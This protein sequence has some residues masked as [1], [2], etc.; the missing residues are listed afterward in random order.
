MRFY[1]L[2]AVALVTLLSTPLSA[3]PRLEL[4]Q[5]DHICLI[6]NTL[7]DRMQH[8]GWLET[9]L[10]SRFPD[11]ELVIRNLGFAG[12]EVTA[13]PRSKNFGDPDSHL[14]HSK[15]D[16]IFVF[17]GYNESFGDRRG[18]DEFKNDLAELVYHMEGQ[19]YN[20]ESAPRIVL[21]SPIGHENLGSS[22]LPSGI[23]NN[24]R[25]A[26]Y[27]RAIH[28]VAEEKNL[29]YVDLVGPST[30][31]YDSVGPLTIN[32]IHLTEKGNRH[33]AEVIDQALFGGRQS[34]SEVD[35]KLLREAILDK[36][37]HW[38]NRYR[39]TDGYSQFGNRAFL[40]F[41]DQ[42]DNF[43]VMQRELERLDVMT[44]NR[45]RRIWAIARGGDLEVQDDNLPEHVPVISNFMGKNEDGSH[46]FVSGEA[47][48]EKMTLADGIRVE[49]FASEETFPE[50]ANPVQTAIDT[51]GRLWVAAWPT[52]PHWTPGQPLDDKL[53]IL[54]DEDADGKA[55]ECIVFADDLHNPTGFEFWGGGVIVA[56]APD[57]LFLED[58]D[59]DDRADRKIRILNGIDSADTH[60]TANAFVIGPAG[61]LYFQRGVF[62]HTSIETPWGPTFRSTS[63]SVYR[64]HPRSY[65]FERH[66]D[67][68]P[69]PHGDTFDRWGN[70]FTTDGTS[71]R[72]YYIGFPGRGAPKDLYQQQYRPVPAI[73]IL[74]SEHFPESLQGDL[75]ILNVI[76]FQGIAR[77]KFSYEGASIHAEHVEQ[78]VVSSDRNFR[79]SDLEIGSD[80]S[81]YFIDWHNPI[82]GHMQHNLRD[83]NRD[84]RHGRVYRIVAEGRE[85]TK[86]VKM[87]GHPIGELLGHLKSPTDSV[88]YR[89]RLEL[90][91]RDSH[92]VITAANL[93]ATNIDDK[94]P[95]AAHFL[96]E[97]LWL[98]QQHD[99]VQ[100]DL[101][102]RVLR[103]SEPRARAAA[104]RVLR[105]WMDDLSNAEDLLVKL[106]GDDDP[107]VR[108]EA[109]VAS[110]KASPLVGARIIFEAQRWPTDPQIDFNLAEAGKSIDMK[111][112]IDALAR[113]GEELPPP[114]YSYVLN[115]FSAGDI[116]RL[117]PASEEVF[118]EV[119]KRPEATREQ[120][121]T[122]IAKLT[123]QRGTDA[124]TVILDTI[125]K[126]KSSKSTTQ[127]DALA[128]LLAS[129]PH[130]T[131]VNV[132]P[133]LKEIALQGETV[134][135]RRAGLAGWIASERSVVRV[136]ED[137]PKGTDNLRAVLKATALVPAN[138]REDLYD[139]VR[140]IFFDNAG[141]VKDLVQDPGVQADY[142]HPAPPNALLETFEGL[143][144]T[145]TGTVENISLHV[146]HRGEHEAF[147]LRFRT[148]LNVA[149][150]GEHTLYLKS[151]DGS[152]LYLNGKMLIDND[153]HHGAVEVA[154]KAQL[155][156][157]PHNLYVTYFNGQSATHLELDWSG[158]SFERQPVPASS[159]SRPS[160]QHVGD[161]AIRSLG[162]VKG[163]ESEIFGDLAVLIR[164]GVHRKS[165]IHVL[166]AI[167]STHWLKGEL[168]SLAESL[169]DHVQNIPA[170]ERTQPAAL[171]AM[172]LGDRIAA[173]LPE[174]QRRTLQTRLASARV[175]VIRIGTVPH[176]MIFD[177]ERLAIQAGRDVEFI[178]SN[179]DQMPHN[180]AIV[181]PGALEEVGLLAESTAQSSD[182]MKRHYIPASDKVLL[183]SRLLHPG[184]TQALS[185]SAP[186]TPG[187]YP[188]VC[189]YPG[190][191]R[192][193]YGA[194]YV[195][196]DLE[197]YVAN[198]QQYLADHPLELKD[199]LLKF[200]D[201][202]TEWTEAMLADPVKKMH[203]GRSHEVGREVFKVAN[204]SACH[205]I[206]DEGKEIGP[207]LTKLEG[208]KTSREHILKSLL[209]PSASI[210]DRY[211][212][213]VFVLATGDVVT[214]MVLK[215]S[216]DVIKVATDPQGLAP[217]TEIKKADI[218]VREPSAQ[219]IMPKGLLDKL[220][221]EEILDLVA[222]I[223]ARGDREHMLYHGAHEH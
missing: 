129:Q 97:L 9:L 68:G 28:E 163:R 145:S 174:E 14:T 219:S 56:H 22:S 135:P 200:N 131:L 156:A 203:H 82:I 215:E 205:R 202:K 43:V 89:A 207:D 192:R 41:V 27:A 74:S 71:G 39:A 158:P 99:R 211:R 63:S 177:K 33:L 195:V 185:Y 10:Q 26:L 216:N 138:S 172:R 31:L 20:G 86:P 98:H 101:V 159:L 79:P 29:P 218:Q 54:P 44:A 151:D 96:T 84:Q 100:P 15:A 38:A 171:E 193:M 1:S 18:L 3:A 165:A 154:G 24:Q 64:F 30:K 113:P 199:T 178:F 115:N 72:G 143:A 197:A 144:P 127:A 152:R 160:S 65:R 166:A 32:G 141:N 49:L 188:Y 11:H 125:R 93:L 77:Y 194:L 180:F 136:L 176:R 23:E 5:G 220:S 164:Q 35:L 91:A 114:A 111:A 60:H 206:N 161:L 59:G 196:E 181:E 137:S 212:S 13:R 19:K 70:Q 187:I 45:D 126:N 175:Q 112:A 146:P 213:Y 116:L 58:T 182:A 201:R 73:G 140:S 2:G 108:A 142:F 124:T 149:E 123:E 147:G 76:G 208:E 128:E 57:I 8:H 6:G 117:L 50:L 85:L 80:G 107:R 21:F 34:V 7:A 102:E 62:H 209:D 94:E 40:K 87:K 122:A 51:D 221:R 132:R 191:W 16:V 204:C 88:R 69:N 48:I 217:A 105:D 170:R 17:F 67:V 25:I 83:P 104:T 118:L 168:L 130:E 155:G 46:E 53:I 150:N 210:D 42:Q 183:G 55:D 109:V 106:A 52:Y 214:G 75:L 4:Q 121:A 148:V 66:F 169:A 36:N 37:L 95:G 223:L 110:V 134:L 179:T 90:S 92:Q 198:P 186:T 61:W 184:E 78:F 103:S 153:G 190:H 189:T 173:K 222:Y 47:A 81:I 133:T 157:G 162:L 139:A 12:D 119:L 120:V 167:D